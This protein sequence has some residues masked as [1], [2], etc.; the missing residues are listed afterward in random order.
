MFV[1]CKAFDTSKSDFDALVIPAEEFLDFCTHC[2]NVFC[3]EF[4]DDNT[5]RYNIGHLTNEAI[6]N[7]DA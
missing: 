2:G 6:R 7:L 5:T 4:D 1:Q 3:K